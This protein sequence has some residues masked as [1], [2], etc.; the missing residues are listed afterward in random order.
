MY[1]PIGFQ[2]I[3]E[4]ESALTRGTSHI[5]L[6][7]DLNFHIVVWGSRSDPCGAYLWWWLCTKNVSITNT[8]SCTFFRGAACLVI[9]LSI[10]SP[11]VMVNSWAT[12]DL[13]CKNNHVSIIFQVTAPL[14]RY[15]G[16]LRTYVN[17]QFSVNNSQE[18]FHT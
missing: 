18:T 6:A 13:G 10:S 7:G 3:S 12:V 1:F 8:G 5:F 15:S 14:N 4:L 2:S 9:D 16:Q 11:G 17:F